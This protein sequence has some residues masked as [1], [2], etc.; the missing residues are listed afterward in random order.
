MR[1]SF[2]LPVYNV[3]KYLCQCIDS[4]IMQDNNNYEIILIDDGSSDKCPK[5]LASDTPPFVL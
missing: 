3:E 2:I 1:Y 4:I 5:F